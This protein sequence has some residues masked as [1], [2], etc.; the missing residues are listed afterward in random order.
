MDLLKNEPD[1]MEYFSPV[2]ENTKKKIEDAYNSRELRI[3]TSELPA[4]APLF[5]AELLE[6]FEIFN[7]TLDNSWPSFME[8]CHT[9]KSLSLHVFKL[10]EFPTWIRNAV[11]L[12]RL[13][14]KFSEFKFIPDWI[15]E[16][17]SLTELNFNDNKHLKVIPDSICNLKNLVKLDLSGSPIENLPDSIINCTSLEYLD[18]RQTNIVLPPNS[19][20]Q[21]KTVR[22]SIELIPKEHS[23]SYRTFC[24]CYYKLAETI[25]RF[26]VKSKKDFLSL[27]DDSKD[28]SDD[29][30]C[31][32]IQLTVDG[33]EEEL[34]RHILTLRVEREHG[35]YR[36]K[37]MEIAM[38]GI[39]CIQRN[40]STNRTAFMLVALVNIENNLLDA[41]LTK[42]FTSN[43]KWPEAIDFNAAI[44]P[45]EEREEVLFLKRAT[46][47]SKIA[48]DESLFSLEKLLDHDR[49]AAKDIFEIGLTFVIDGTESETIDKIL[50]IMISHE[51]DP[52][53]KNLALAKKDAVLM[54]NKRYAP[55][56]IEATLLAYFDNSITKDFKE[57][58]DEL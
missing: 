27:E 28:F 29:F 18:I 51:T 1:E 34:I 19:I 12:Q 6:N 20:S 40:D 23:I 17:K 30:F 33:E 25:I 3:I 37:L 47:L 15:G 16:L 53:R 8:K 22:Q 41:V 43:S 38:E 56:H 49:M 39:L 42:G 44:Q 58:I 55:W 36:K 10:T 50:S 48:W 57:F 46:A 9:L 35:Y 32:G 45:E 21:I 54:L 31:Q 5:E 13:S 26:S 24:N 7:S 52:V 4:T 14:I 2:V 11:S